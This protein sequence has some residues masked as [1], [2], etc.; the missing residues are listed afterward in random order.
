MIEDHDKFNEI[1]STLYDET[2]SDKGDAK[3]LIKNYKEQEAKEI[4]YA[5][6]LNERIAQLRD[7][8]VTVTESQ[9]MCST[10]C[11][12]YYTQTCKFLNFKTKG[13]LQHEAEFDTGT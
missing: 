2:S 10:A 4:N 8:N 7:R 13:E 9:E 1:V 6:Q 3:N 5:S 11:H 12:A